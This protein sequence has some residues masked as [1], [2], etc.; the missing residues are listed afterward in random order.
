M[1]L[2]S[3]NILIPAAGVGSRFSQAGYT[4]PKPLIEVNGKPMIQL[5]VD[6]L[7]EKLL[8]QYMELFFI[9]LFQKEHIN[10]YDLEDMV[11]QIDTSSTIVAVDG[12]TD[13]A[14][15][16]TL[17]ARDYI[18]S[19][20]PLLI[21]NSDQYIEWDVD[22]FP[23]T[24]FTS[25]ENVDAG[26]LT[27]NSVHPKWSYARLDDRGFVAEVAEKRPISDLATVGIYYWK[28]GSDYVKYADQMIKKNVRTNN[29]FYVCPVFNEAIADG[30]LVR[31]KNIKKMWGIGTPEDLQ[32]YL[33]AHKQ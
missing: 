29:E 3:L 16:T 23:N 17:L 12:I 8:G 30:K 9:F 13:G 15:R 20:D 24:P 2:K 6:N 26:I 18:D 1:I 28:R 11:K 33:E 22:V 21:S 19:D 10:K 4:F 5:V 31:V 25:F 27:F 7:K 32:T 14:A